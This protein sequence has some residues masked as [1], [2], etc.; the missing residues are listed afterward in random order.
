MV[1]WRRPRAVR[2]ERTCSARPSPA[3]F[4]FAFA[5]AARAVFVFVFVFALAARAVF[6]FVFAFAL[7]A[8][9]GLEPGRYPRVHKKIVISLGRWRSR[10]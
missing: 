6:V 3:V 10:R 8:A 2:P 9:L 5:L 1:W 4:V 7:A